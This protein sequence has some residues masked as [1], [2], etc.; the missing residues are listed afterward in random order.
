MD[1]TKGIWKLH[2]YSCCKTLG[3]H[4]SLTLGS[5]RILKLCCWEKQIRNTDL[6]KIGC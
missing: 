1:L 5:T 3:K 2:G 4:V 6:W